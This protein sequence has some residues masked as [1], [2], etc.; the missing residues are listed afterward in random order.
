MTNNKPIIF[1]F[2]AWY[3]DD[4]TGKTI[5]EKDIENSNPSIDMVENIHGDKIQME[6]EI[7]DDEGQEHHME[8]PTITEPII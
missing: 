8:Q 5:K 3:Y 1:D 7:N 2:Q 4:H 6:V